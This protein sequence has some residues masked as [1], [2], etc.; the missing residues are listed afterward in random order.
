MIWPLV[1]I[2]RP[3]TVVE[4][5]RLGACRPSA[6]NCARPHSGVDVGAPP[7]TVVLA[8]ISGVLRWQKWPG[9][10]GGVVTSA[11]RTVVIG[12]LDATRVAGAV[13]AGEEIGRLVPYPGGSQL[14]HL[15]VW[16]GA[17]T[18]STRYAALVNARPDLPAAVLD[19][20]AETWGADLPDAAD[21]PDVDPAPKKGTNAPRGSLGASALAFA[22]VVGVLSWRALRRRT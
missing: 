19:P 10:S 13:A 11:D 20:L 17:W 12:P 16:A 4:A 2:A 9:G 1:G 7:T 3:I 6:K 14:A 21:L 15:E 8:P 5:R 22:A 18:P